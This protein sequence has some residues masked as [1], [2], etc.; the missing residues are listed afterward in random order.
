MQLGHLKACDADKSHC[1]HLR[2]TPGAPTEAERCVGLQCVWVHPIFPA[3]N[4]KVNF[5]LICLRVC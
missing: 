2:E 4:P 5:P 3:M 1:Y